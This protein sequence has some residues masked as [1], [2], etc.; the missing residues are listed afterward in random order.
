MQRGQ[1]GSIKCSSSTGRWKNLLLK[2]G[3]NVG[4][5][6]PAFD[7]LVHKTIVLKQGKH[8]PTVL[9]GE[10]PD[11]LLHHLEDTRRPLPQRLCALHTHNVV[12]SERAGGTGESTQPPETD[13]C[14][15]APEPNR[16]CFFSYSLGK[17]SFAFF[18]FP[19]PPSTPPWGED[20]KL[21]Y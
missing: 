18:L 5:D 2:L 15:L 3:Q 14:V 13:G 20:G 11:Q 12:N 17:V 21:F 19:P 7:G 16:H 10:A 8:V 9:H 6:G 4:Y 1:T